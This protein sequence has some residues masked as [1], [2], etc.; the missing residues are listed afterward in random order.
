M[1][2]ANYLNGVRGHDRA[3]A[4]KISRSQ[5][6]TTLRV[7]TGADRY[8]PG[9]Y[10][11]DRNFVEDT[12][13]EVR[14]GVLQHAP[15]RWSFHLDS[16][17]TDQDGILKGIRNPGNMKNW[18]NPTCP[19]QYDALDGLEVPARVQLQSSPSYSVR[20]GEPAELVRERRIASSNPG[21]GH[22]NQLSRFDIIRHQREKEIASKKHAKVCRW[23]SQFQHIFQCFHP[24]K[25]QNV[26]RAH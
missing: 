22:Y 14:A 5:S 2:Y 8:E 18:F 4:W 6:D 21:P 24:K 13:S 26:R 17:R 3:P 15:A 12:T 9:M 11:V 16:S 10:K 23:E 20:K 1:Q 7:K 19:G 25:S